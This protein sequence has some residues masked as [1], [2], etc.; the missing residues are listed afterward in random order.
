MYGIGTVIFVLHLASDNS[1]IRCDRR[2]D[3][4]TE[5]YSMLHPLMVSLDFSEFDLSS[6]R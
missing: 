5:K 4:L 2:A 6:C 3:H 1:A